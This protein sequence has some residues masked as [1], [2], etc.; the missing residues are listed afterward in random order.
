[1][2]PAVPAVPRPR[3]PRFPAIHSFVHRAGRESRE[4]RGHGR[5]ARGAQGHGARGAQGHDARAG[6]AAAG[7]QRET[8]RP[9]VVGVPAAVTV[10]ECSI[11]P[12]LPQLVH[13]INIH[14]GLK[15]KLFS[16]VPLQTEPIYL[17]FSFLRSTTKISFLN[18][19]G[20]KITFVLN[21]PAVLLGLVY[22]CG[23]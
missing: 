9:E 4:C 13:V 11:Q 8:W 2:V 14:Q 10:N 6:G 23:R 5:G 17:T 3:C 15:T 22:F 7:A 20:I 21:V 12:F 16:I 18:R 1:M 19:F